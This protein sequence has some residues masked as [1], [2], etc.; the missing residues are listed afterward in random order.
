MKKPADQ[1]KA[2]NMSGSAGFE[3]ANGNLIPQ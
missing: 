3:S 2:E 1:L